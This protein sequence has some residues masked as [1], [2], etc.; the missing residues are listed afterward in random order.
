[1]LMM[2]K[3]VPSTAHCVLTA[4]APSKPVQVKSIVNVPMIVGVLWKLP[5]E[6]IVQALIPKLLMKNAVFADT[7]IADPVASRAMTL[8]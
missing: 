8:T 4:F 7:Q 2:E 1:M 5:G 3:V 6:L